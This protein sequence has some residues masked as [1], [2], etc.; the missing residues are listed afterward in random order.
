VLQY[1]YRGCRFTRLV[2]RLVF[3]LISLTLHPTVRIHIYRFMK[4]LVNK[5]YIIQF[6][7]NGSRK[8]EKKMLVFIDVIHRKWTFALKNFEDCVTTVEPHAKSHV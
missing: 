1:Y 7:L 2:Q 8:D 5:L 3:G 4:V 6:T